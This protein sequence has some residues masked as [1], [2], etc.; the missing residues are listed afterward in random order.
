M[1]KV[2]ALLVIVLSAIGTWLLTSCGTQAS[3]SLSTAP[4]AKPDFSL[5]A[6]PTTL[7][8]TAGVAGQTVSVTANALNGFAGSVNVSLSGLPTG[9][10][11]S[12]STLT[13]TPGTAQSITLTAAANAAPG[14][15]TITVTGTSGSLS[16]TAIVVLTVSAAAPAPDFMLM[17]APTTLSLT[18][19]NAGQT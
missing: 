2:P 3:N 5:T 17:V 10:T 19:G 9:V 1:R 4:S 11:A 18:A 7:S 15:A 6:S 16:H 13:L 8:L 14:M 12:P